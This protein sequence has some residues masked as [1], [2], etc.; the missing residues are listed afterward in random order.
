MKI[1]FLEYVIKILLNIQHDLSRNIQSQIGSDTGGSFKYLF[2][3]HIIL[4][5][6]CMICL[7]DLLY[8][9]KINFKND[10]EIE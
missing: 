6:D 5:N 7:N 10:V 2:K 4:H 1:C 8:G 9:Y 3:L